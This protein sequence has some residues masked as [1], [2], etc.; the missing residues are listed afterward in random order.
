MDGSGGDCAVWKSGTRVHVKV[1]HHSN[2][3]VRRCLGLHGG[4]TLDGP[5]DRS[6]RSEQLH[7]LVVVTI[8]SLKCCRSMPVVS[9]SK[10]TSV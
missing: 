4:G 2:R 1:H 8:L 6:E 9:S 3:Q 10:H 7:G 5:L